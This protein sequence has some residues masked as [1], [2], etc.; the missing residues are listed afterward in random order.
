MAKINDFEGIYKRQGNS[1][2]KSLDD[3]V[4]KMLIAHRKVETATAKKPINFILFSDGASGPQYWSS[5]YPTDA[6]NIYSAEY[7]GTYFE[8][9]VDAEG[10]TIR[11]REAK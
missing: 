2:V 7:A 10:L 5:L 9:E 8:V 6:G 1:F 4:L 11:E 3:Q